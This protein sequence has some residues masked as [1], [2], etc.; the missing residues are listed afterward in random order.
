MVAQLWKMLYLL[1]SGLL[2]LDAFLQLSHSLLQTRLCA[3][4]VKIHG[5]VLE[6]SRIRDIFPYA[7]KLFIMCLRH[8]SDAVNSVAVLMAAARRGALS[9]CS[10]IADPRHHQDVSS[11]VCGHLCNSVYYLHA[12]SDCKSHGYPDSAGDTASAPAVWSRQVT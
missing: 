11:I 7:C 1:Q 5:V 3:G 9:C 12:M 10:G 4:C 6:F 8:C 2:H